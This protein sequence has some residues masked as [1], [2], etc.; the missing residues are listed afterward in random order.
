MTASVP[1]I[2]HTCPICE[3]TFQDLPCHY[4]VY[5][6]IAC[7]AEARRR[8]GKRLI[9]QCDYCGETF[10]IPDPS[11]WINRS[12][13]PLRFCSKTCAGKGVAQEQGLH[14]RHEK[15]FICN[16]CGTQF[17]RMARHDRNYRFCSRGC[18]RAAYRGDQ[19]AY[20]QG[21]TDRYYGPNWTNDRLQVLKRD[22]Y[23]CQE[24]RDTGDGLHVHHIVPRS[25]FGHDWVAM[26]APSNLITLC[27]HCHTR[28]HVSERNDTRALP[29]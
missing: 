18:F 10:I 3:R 28:L 26:N 11:Q 22:G 2:P 21:G 17:T 1:R 27:V 15:T 25:Q 8:S 4:R 6:S 29:S 14:I 13:S 20:W 19:H 16:Y 12:H 9:R 24:C 7:R 5:C 23:T